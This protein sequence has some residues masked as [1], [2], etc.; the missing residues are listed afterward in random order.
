MT[1]EKIGF[2]HIIESPSSDD[3]LDGQTEGKSLCASFELSKIPHCYN[4]VTNEESFKKALSNRLLDAWKKFKPT[5]PYLHLSMHGN[6]DGI[7]LTDGKI[8]TW[9]ELYNCLFP[10]IKTMDGNLIITMSTCEGA[11]GCKMAF[12][13]LTGPTFL[14]IIGNTESTN[15]DDASVAYTVFYHNL[16][17]GKALND[18]VIAMQMASGDKNF[19]PLDGKTLQNS[20]RKE[21]VRLLKEKP[22]QPT[23]L[24]N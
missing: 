23:S 7:E 17:K 9:S 18:C 21:L 16:M 24:T 15:W 13:N 6:N 3:L 1:S 10:L 11:A 14:A 8:F 20:A 2:V 4:L 12:Q 5:V 19:L 22:P